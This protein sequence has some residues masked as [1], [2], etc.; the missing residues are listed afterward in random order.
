MRDGK[1]RID[2]RAAADRHAR[3]LERITEQVRAFARARRPVSFRKAAVSHQVPKLHDATRDDDKV[4]LTGLAEILELVPERRFCVAE[5]G[6]TFDQLVD[7]TLPHGLMPTVVPELRTITVGGAVA[8]CS[9]ESG[10]FMYGGL[11]D[12]C[13]RYEVITARGDVLEVTP[14]DADP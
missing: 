14:D 8:G 1:P 5:A 2:A 10:S 11:H 7:A 6:V 3:K 4:D 9:I 12:S 13:V